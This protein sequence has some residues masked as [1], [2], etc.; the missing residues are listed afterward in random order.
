MSLANLL[1]VHSVALVRLLIEMLKTSSLKTDPYETLVVISL[2]LNM[3]P[4]TLALCSP[5]A[6]AF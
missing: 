4:L 1:R 5:L 2:H 3:E 6:V